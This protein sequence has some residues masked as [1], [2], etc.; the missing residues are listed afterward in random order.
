MPTLR[1]GDLRPICLVVT[2]EP[3]LYDFRRPS[4]FSRGHV[5]ALQIVDDTFARQFALVLSTALRASCQVTVAAVHQ[6][7]GDEYTRTVAN[8]SLLAVLDLDPLPGAGVFQLPMSI[9]M[10]IVDRLLGG[11][12]GPDQP[13]RA[14]SDIEVGIIRQLLQRIV[15]EL[16]YAFE[17]LTPV[18]A[19]VGGLESDPQFLQIV[20]P[21]EPVIVVEFAI[22]IGEQQAT[23][24]LCLPFATLEPALDAISESLVTHRTE[25]DERAAQDVERQLN[26]VPVELSIRFHEV[27]VTSSQ[28]LTLAIGDVLPLRHPVNQPLVML[29]DGVEVAAAVPGSHGQRLAC[30]IVSLEGPE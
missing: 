4:R 17:S 25:K 16:N 21:S 1:S 20:A 18:N 9:V 27:T 5:R 13:N 23:S 24:S 22:R 30:Q 2:S 29:A 10:S 6:L 19:T 26:A 11:P 3:A 28:I 15:H 12:G 8:P 14:L 7:T